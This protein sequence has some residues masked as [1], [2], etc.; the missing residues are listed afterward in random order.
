MRILHLTPELPYAPGGTGGSTRQFHL[1]RRLVEFGHE[2][3]VVAPVTAEQSE[4]AHL[5]E[6]AGIETALVPRP[7]R[8]GAE[9]LGALARRPGLVAAAL[10][11]PVLAWQAEVLWTRL[12]APARRLASRWRPDVL[13]VEHD[14]SA[15]WLCEL[16]APPPAVLTLQNVSSQYYRRRS[17]A[18]GGLSSLALGLEARRF[19]AFDRRRLGPYRRVIAV[20]E[21]D[22][23]AAR[24][25]CERPVDV[26]PNGVDVR[27]FPALASDP[28]GPPTLLF[29]GTLDYPPNT[30]GLLWFAHQV[31]PLLR[32]RRP[33]LRLLVVGR[34]PPE[35]V[36][37][38]GRLP[39]VQVVGPV[40]EMVPWY[41]R[42]TAVIVPLRSGGGTRLKLLEALAG[43]RAVVS[44]TAGA[45]G[46]DVADERDVLLV[47]DDPGR[48]A[49]ATLRLLEDPALRARLAERGRALVQERY[50]WPAL[51]ELLEAALVRAAQDG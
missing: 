46:I 34:S 18:S 1:L 51:G 27:A 24:E 2:V 23:T 39:G 35:P 40:P 7:A 8:R 44:T 50:D 13:S 47:P 9:A 42:A 21:P 4:R 22:A 29:T 11:T 15:R 48:F 12:R 49:A 33:A 28:D 19:E 26:V 25:L 41:G 17:Q 10:T 37:A 6:Q 16:P 45:E 32:E 3:S 30:E 36:L 20:S 14:W 38:L 43:G 5:L 31:W